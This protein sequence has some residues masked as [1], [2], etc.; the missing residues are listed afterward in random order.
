M[1]QFTIHGFRRKFFRNLN[2]P[3]QPEGRYI[4]CLIWDVDTERQDW[5]ESI[6]SIFP[7]ISACIV[8]YFTTHSS[9]HLYCEIHYKIHAFKRATGTNMTPT[10]TNMDKS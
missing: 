9:M 4:D 7:R 5:S 6:Y 1:K 10:W 8:I 2:E 3:K